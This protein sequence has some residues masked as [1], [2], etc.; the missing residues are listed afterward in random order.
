MSGFLNQVSS[1][2]STSQTMDLDVQRG[3]RAED[4]IDYYVD[5]HITGEPSRTESSG[6][7]ML[8]TSH[9][10]R[11]S[12]SSERNPSN[13]R[14]RAH[15]V[16]ETEREF[17]I[18]G[19]DEFTSRGLYPTHS[20]S[21]LST[22]SQPTFSNTSAPARPSTTSFP[23]IITFHHTSSVDPPPPPKTRKGMHSASHVSDGHL[24]IPSAN[25]PHTT[26]KEAIKR[27]K[28]SRACDPC[29]RKKIRQARRSLFDIACSL[30]TN[31]P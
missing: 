14:S 27:T 9:A 16:R 23:T 8:S 12:T 26:N 5:N 24:A 13:H 6:G 17:I 4:S 11:T 1:E 29:R 3:S 25:S 19:P 22:P 30:Y 10:R 31:P 15:S 2:R 21:N 7:S 18:E 20:T 28:T